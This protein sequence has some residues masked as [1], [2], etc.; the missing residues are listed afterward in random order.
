[1]NQ[2]KASASGG[3]V[4]TRL[5]YSNDAKI[6]SATFYALVRSEQQAD[7]LRSHGISPVLFT[8]LHDLES[9]RKLASEYDILVNMAISYNKDAAKAFILG[10]SGRK[11]RG[12]E[13]IYI[14]V[15]SWQLHCATC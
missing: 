4:L 6:S 3:S 11:K 7:I 9:V 10:L 12:K 14:H 2:S 8:G 15:L 5:Q 1:M 13:G